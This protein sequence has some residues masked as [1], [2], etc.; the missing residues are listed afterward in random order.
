MFGLG[1]G[2]Y[3]TDRIVHALP[4]LGRT[5]HPA[6]PQQSSPHALNNRLLRALLADAEAWE[7]A[8]FEQEQDAPRSFTQLLAQAA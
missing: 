7:Y 3:P 6:T 1:S 4:R 8:T 2:T 5:M